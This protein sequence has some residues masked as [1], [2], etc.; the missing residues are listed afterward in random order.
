M[1]ADLSIEPP[2]LVSRSDELIAVAP[3]VLDRFSEI[4]VMDEFAETEDGEGDDSD[5]DAARP[6]GGLH[7]KVFVQENGWD[8]AITI[9]SG[10]ATRPALLTGRNVEVFATLTG[11]RSR[12]GS[13]SDIFG[14]DGFGRVL[15]AFRPAEIPQ[16]DAGQRAAEQ[17]IER[18]RRELVNAGLALNCTAREDEESGKGLWKVV[19]QPDQA[20]RFDGLGSV[21]CWLITTGEAHAHDVL[22]PL[23]DGGSIE[24][25]T[26]PLIDVTRYVAFRLTDATHEE[27]TALFALGLRIS[28]LPS[29]RHQAVLRWVLDGKAFLRYLRLLLAD[30]SDPLSTQFAAGSAEGGGGGWMESVDDEPILEDMVRALSHGH[31]RLSAVQRLMERLERVSTDDGAPV[32]PEDFVRLWDA[33]RAILDE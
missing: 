22:M 17:R 19:L 25:G 1:L 26:M 6:L 28:G 16:R 20:V 23:R 2:T 18:A 29:T 27:T 14:P 8:T 33:F 30:T 5:E 21:T 4:S 7:A 3:R 9:G 11:K 13:I 10:N 24:I 32:V 15:R 12:V 31:D